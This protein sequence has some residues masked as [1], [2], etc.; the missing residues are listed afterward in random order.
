MDIKIKNIASINFMERLN[1]F[2]GG[3]IHLAILKEEWLSRGILIN[4]VRGVEAPSFTL[5]EILRATVRSMT[6][7]TNSFSKFEAND[8]IIS[9]SPYPPDV[10]LA[11]RLSRKIGM[12]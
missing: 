10:I 12:R 5:L 8:I 2:G 11:H 9:E 6:I 7:N 4:K 1:K 3:G